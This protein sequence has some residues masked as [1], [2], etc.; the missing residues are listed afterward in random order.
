MYNEI[1]LL[2][3]LKN[4]FQI[5]KIYLKPSNSLYIHF[6]TKMTKFFSTNYNMKKGEINSMMSTKTA[7]RSIMSNID[8]AFVLCA[9]GED[10]S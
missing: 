9:E 7:I 3:F 4:F 10:K 6:F 8:E 1:G 5:L 2:N